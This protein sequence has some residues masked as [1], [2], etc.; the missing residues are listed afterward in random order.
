M[1]KWFW[2]AVLAYIVSLL[3][4]FYYPFLLGD[5]YYY[6]GWLLNTNDGYFYAQGA[7]DLLL[8]VKSTLHSPINEM[9]SQITAFLA[10]ILPLSLEQIIFYMSGFFG[11]V[12]VFLVVY[13]ARHFGGIISF[14]CGVLSGIGVS[15]YNRTMFGYYDT[16]ML[17][18][19]LGLL[20]GVVIFDMLMEEVQKE[21]ERI[22]NEP[23]V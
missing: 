14:L 3:L 22:E 12:I 6:K 20:V 15:Y 2:W 21:I 7:R 9:L 1:K 18:V 5:L 13:L 16:D 17:V 10:W 23:V 19:V 4:R 8:G 11:C